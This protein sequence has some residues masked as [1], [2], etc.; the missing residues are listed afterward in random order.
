MKKK[1]SIVCA[2]IPMEC[3]HNVMK[4]NTDLTT[5]LPFANISVQ[6]TSKLSKERPKI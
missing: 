3:L 1:N 4:S 2:K 6:S 5:I